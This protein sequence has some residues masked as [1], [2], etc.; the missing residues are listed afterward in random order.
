MKYYVIWKGRQ[1]GIF[2]SW[3]EVQ[4][5]VSGFSDAKFKSFVTLQEAEAAFA[6]SWQEFYAQSSI[7]LWKAWQKDPSL[8]IPFHS[9]ALAVDAA[10]SGNP[11]VLERRGVLVAS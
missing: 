2:T 4:A 5:L 10:C 7:S 9:Q 8:L 6:S 11:G 1:Q 3:T